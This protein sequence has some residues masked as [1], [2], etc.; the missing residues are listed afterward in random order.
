M[1]IDFNHFINKN[2]TF[3]NLGNQIFDALFQYMLSP[4]SNLEMS[5]ISKT[6]VTILPASL[7]LKH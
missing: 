6:F 3:N 1:K 7:Y 5:M 2:M 4:V